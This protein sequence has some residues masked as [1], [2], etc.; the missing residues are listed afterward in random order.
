MITRQISDLLNDAMRCD[1]E[2]V[3]ALIR[4]RVPCNESLADHPRIIATANE[5]EVTVNIIGLLNGL[6]DDYRDRLCV[7]MDSVTL[8]VVGFGIV[9][10]NLK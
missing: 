6:V 7:K 10:G 8:D 2:A 3:R 1:P 5:G 9:G 4:H